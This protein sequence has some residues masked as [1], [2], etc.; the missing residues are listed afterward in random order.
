MGRLHA[1]HTREQVS[2]RVSVCTLRGVQFFHS[3]GG[4]SDTRQ[5]VDDV[6]WFHHKA[7]VIWTSSFAHQQRQSTLSY[8]CADVPSQLF[9]SVYI[10]R[11][12]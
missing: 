6:K 5:S 3:A 9:R 1:F 4:G 2:V 8:L 7:A 12:C 11:S 10:Q